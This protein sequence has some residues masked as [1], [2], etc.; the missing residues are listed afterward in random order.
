MIPR[1]F[2]YL[3]LA[4]CLSCSACTSS[5]Q[6][7]VAAAYEQ[8]PEEIDFNFHVRPISIGS[9]FFLSRP[10]RKC[11]KKQNCDWIWKKWHLPD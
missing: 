7:P 9:L 5:M 10:G 2:N 1:A 4:I 3:L 8:L 6:E 11:P